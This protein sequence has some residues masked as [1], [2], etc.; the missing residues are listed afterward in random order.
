MCEIAIALRTRKKTPHTRTSQVSAK[1]GL[2]L[3]IA[4]CDFTSQLATCNRTSQV[5]PWYLLKL[6]NNCFSARSE[7]HLVN[8]QDQAGSSLILVGF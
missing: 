5:M 4:T 7:Y 3:H 1:I 2:H 8:N 6:R